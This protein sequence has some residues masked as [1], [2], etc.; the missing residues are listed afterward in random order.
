MIKIAHLSDL[1]FSHISLFPFHLKRFVGLSN[2]ILNRKKSYIEKHLNKV[3]A[4]LKKKEIN[5]VLI[6]GDLTCT[7]H[8]KEFE[9]AKNFL[10]SFEKS[11]FFI[12]AGNHD[13]YIKPARDNVH[14]LNLL[15]SDQF[16]K[17]KID[18]QK[19][20]DKWVY[21]G[22][23]CTYPSSL[24]SAEGDF[25]NEIEK[26][27]MNTLNAI[28]R[29][30]NILVQ[31]HFPIFHNAKKRRLLKGRQRLEELL[32]RYPNVK[33]YLHGHTHKASILK[34][35]KLPYMICSG[36]TSHK[37]K[38][39]FNIFTL[40]DLSFDVETYSLKDNDWFLERTQTLSL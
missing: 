37:T 27:L 3:Q 33:I 1:H 5:T 15:S 30:K 8:K 35:E 2:L 28:S 10:N 23:D 13:S 38:G 34:K 40:K 25:T 14:F 4:I 39:S 9:K 26:E 11:E 20:S 24:F 19:L 21:I 31:N 17:S 16:T 6:S 7:S 18:F 29:D 36:C 12:V 32:K 22:I